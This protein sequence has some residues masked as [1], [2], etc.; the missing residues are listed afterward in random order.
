MTTLA[1]GGLFLAGGF[2]DGSRIRNDAPALTRRHVYVDTMGIHPAAVRAAIDLLG[3]DHVLMGTDWPIVEEKS[4]PER[5]AKALAHS[6]LSATEQQM[7][8]SGNTL[9]LLGVT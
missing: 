8:A 3:A 6:G 7:V 2:G 9:K 4:V 5:L 1:I